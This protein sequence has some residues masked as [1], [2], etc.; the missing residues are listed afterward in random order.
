MEL[1]LFLHSSSPPLVGSPFLQL[2]PVVPCPP[3][4]TARCLQSSLPPPCTLPR[5]ASAALLPSPRE[6]RAFTSNPLSPALSF[7]N[8]LH[9]ITFS[10]TE[11]KKT[12]KRGL[13]TDKPRLSEAS[14]SVLWMFLFTS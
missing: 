5:A 1:G 13:L 6:A 2:Q 7:L 3:P 4:W 11:G 10:K 12:V 14:E 9:T 8:P